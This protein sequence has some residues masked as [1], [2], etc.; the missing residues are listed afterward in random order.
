MTDYVVS[1]GQVTSGLILNAGDTE[2]VLSG[3]TAFATTVNN[4]GLLTVSSGGRTQL[5]NDQQRRQR[6]RLAG[7]HRRLGDH[8]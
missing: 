3:G 8:Q 7:R 6:G 4:G 2:T 5:Q 1:S